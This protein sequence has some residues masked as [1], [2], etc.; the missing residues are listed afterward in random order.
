[1]KNLG[2]LNYFLGLKIT[3]SDDGFY[4]TQ[5]KYTF[6]L[7]S[8]ASPTNHKIVDTPIE[9]NVRLTPSREPLPDPTLYQQFVGSLVYLT[10]TWPA[11]S[12]A[13]H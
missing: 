4:L 3:S 7:L 9:L 13:V 10:V 2:H 5:A 6:D 8:R 12:Y 1:M 11:I